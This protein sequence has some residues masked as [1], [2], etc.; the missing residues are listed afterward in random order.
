MFGQRTSHPLKAASSAPEYNTLGWIYKH[1]HTH[2]LWQVRHCEHV[3]GMQAWT[4]YQVC[5]HETKSKPELHLYSCSRPATI[6]RMLHASLSCVDRLDTKGLVLQ[7]QGMGAL[8]MA[9]HSLSHASGHGVRRPV[10]AAGHAT[11]QMRSP[12]SAPYSI[13]LLSHSH[14]SSPGACPMPPSTPPTHGQS[15]HTAW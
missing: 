5:E 14:T 13:P 2:S 12:M 11:P 3:N 9:W 10:C 6:G 1:A 7:Q 4:A 8:V 15:I